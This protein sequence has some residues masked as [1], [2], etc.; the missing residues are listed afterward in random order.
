MASANQI[1]FTM[2][3][4][5]I[6]STGFVATILF[7][8]NFLLR[9]Q[10]DWNPLKLV[11]LTT[12]LS[13][14]IKPLPVLTAMQR[15]ADWQLANPETNAT[16]GWIQAAGEAGMMA[17]AGI[18]GDAKYRDAMR[19]MGETNGWQPAARMYHADDHCVGQTYAELHLLY[20]DP[21][22]IAPLRERFDAILAKP[23]SAPGLDFTLPN[24]IYLEQWPWCDALFMAPP[25]WPRLYAAA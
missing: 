10:Q 15:G 23:S 12:S 9:S 24:K 1:V 3:N 22:M 4:H 7:L 11:T 19:A 25:A 13:S 21:K 18:S 6:R 20:R 14:E 16:A 8:T 5:F 2:K 17:L